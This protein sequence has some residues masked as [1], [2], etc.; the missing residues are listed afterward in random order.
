MEAS[1]LG[2]FVCL[3][4]V[5]E[6]LVVWGYLFDVVMVQGRLVVWGYLFVW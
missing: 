2:V 6:R 4:M 3:V 5:Q 1:C